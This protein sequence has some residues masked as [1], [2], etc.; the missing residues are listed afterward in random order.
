MKTEQQLSKKRTVTQGQ[1]EALYALACELYHSECYHKAADLFRLLCFYKPDHIKGWL[2]LGG[3][4]QRIQNHEA[5]LSAFIMASLYDPQ[6][7]EPRLY[8]AHS[9]IDLKNLPLALTSAQTAVQLCRYRHNQ[10]RIRVSAEL[11][12]AG[13]KN[14]IAQRYE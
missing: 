8:A 12:C 6:N 11:L 3:S 7:P 4:H 13:L 1:L 2:G 5:A 9:L 14:A 10:D